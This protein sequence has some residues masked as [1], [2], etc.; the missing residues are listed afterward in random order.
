M[1]G[2]NTYLIVTGKQ[3]SGISTAYQRANKHVFFAYRPATTPRSY[4]RRAWQRLAGTRALGRC[5]AQRTFKIVLI[6]PPHYDRDDYV[7]Q[8]RC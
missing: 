7:I 5:I 3:R 2:A 8:W 6:K 1:R 4:L